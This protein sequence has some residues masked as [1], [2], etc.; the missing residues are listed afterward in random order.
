MNQVGREGIL[1]WQSVMQNYNQLSKNEAIQRLIQ[2][3]KI[4]QKIEVIRKSI[5]KVSR[6]IDG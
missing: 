5:D 6:L 4:E 1:H 2:A 3:E